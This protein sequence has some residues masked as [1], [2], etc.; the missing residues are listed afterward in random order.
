[1]VFVFNYN[2][3]Q[4]VQYLNS[5]NRITASVYNSYNSVVQYFELAKVNRSLAEENAKL[6][7]RFQTVT[8][9]EIIADS[10]FRGTLLANPN[11]RYISARVINN[12][13]N[14]KY[15]YITL[16]RGRKQGV[17]PDMGIVS[18]NGI[19]GV[20]TSVSESYAL[21]FS[22]LNSRWGPSAKLKKSGFYGPIEWNGD[23]YQFVKLMEIPFHVEMAVGDTIV[24]SGHSSVFPE[25]IMIGVIQSFSQPE[26]GSFYD[27]NVKLA[28]DFK[29][30]HFVEVIDNIDKEQLKQLEDLTKNGASNN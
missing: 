19:V 9:G 18:N 28:T 24:T 15:N 4:K 7:S 6:K 26:G 5:S 11:Y 21:G 3:Y 23:D 10:V 29:S 17:E 1:M 22:V 12:S 8:S 30:I 2:K 25:G 16:N 14:K 20:V 27:I 13:V